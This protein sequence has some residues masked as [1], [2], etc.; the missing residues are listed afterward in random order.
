[1]LGVAF[2]CIFN[3]KVFEVGEFSQD[4]PLIPLQEFRRSF[5]E[6]AEGNFAPHQAPNLGSDDEEY[7]HAQ[8]REWKL[9]GLTR[10]G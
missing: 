9:P 3:G 10:Q 1:V 8:S 7:L 2:Q 5:P 4:V 6:N